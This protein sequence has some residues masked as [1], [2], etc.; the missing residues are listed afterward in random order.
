VVKCSEVLQCSDG[1]SN[2]VSSIIRRHRQYEVAAFMYFAT[3]IIY[4]V[5]FLFDT[6]VYVFLLLCLSILIVC[7]CIFIVPAGTLRLP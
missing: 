6:V 3:I 2:K 1:L 5:V 7:L 4:M